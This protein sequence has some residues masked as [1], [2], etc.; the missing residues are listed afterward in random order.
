VATILTHGILRARYRTS[1][2][3]PDL[4]EPD[5]MYEIRCGQGITA[6]QLHIVRP[7]LIARVQR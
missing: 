6:Q 3:P 1:F 7:S 4:L 5:A 2:T